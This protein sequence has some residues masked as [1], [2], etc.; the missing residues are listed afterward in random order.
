MLLI[1]TD[2]MIFAE[3]ASLLFLTYVDSLTEALH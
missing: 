3:L 2:R 1:Q